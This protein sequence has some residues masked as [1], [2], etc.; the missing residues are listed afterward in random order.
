MHASAEKSVLEK[1]KKLTELGCFIDR[2][3][4]HESTLCSDGAQHQRELWHQAAIIIL[5][6]REDGE[7]AGPFR[8]Q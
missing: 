6:S 2:V 1:A 3:M 4:L 7:S 5:H 8:D